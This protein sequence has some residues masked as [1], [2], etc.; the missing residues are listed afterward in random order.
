VPGVATVDLGA[1]R[2]DA[3]PA[4]AAGLEQHSV[5]LVLGG[6]G[7]TDLAGTLVGLLDAAGQPDRVG[8]VG[9]PADLALPAGQPC[10]V[11]RGGSGSL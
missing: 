7:L 10:R 5:G 6:V 11:G 4:V 2:A 1:G 8:A 9:G 3:G